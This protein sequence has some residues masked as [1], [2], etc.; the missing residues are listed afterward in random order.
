M[1]SKRLTIELPEA[2]TAAVLDQQKVSGTPHEIYRYPARFSPAF[3]R[4]AIR[5]FTKP[6]DLILDPFCGGGTSVTE[7]I[8]LARRAAAIDISSLA[9]FLTRAKTTPLSVH[10]ARH[11]T[12]WLQSFHKP[13]P[14]QNMPSSTDERYY[15]HL[16]AD[17]SHFFAAVLSRVP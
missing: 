9:T 6:R 14:N 17:I 1:K 12:K 7:A 5:A 11:I 13:L 16:P 15:R 3:A 8:A 2:F 10:D 4:E